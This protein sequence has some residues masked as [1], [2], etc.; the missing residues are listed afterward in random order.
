MVEFVAFRSTKDLGRIVT[1]PQ[2]VR[3]M[4]AMVPEEKS[5]G[6]VSQSM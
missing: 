1:R 4:V 5:L 6:L 3:S 2:S